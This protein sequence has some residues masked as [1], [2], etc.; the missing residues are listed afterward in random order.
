MIGFFD[1]DEAFKEFKQ[2]FESKGLKTRGIINYEK[3]TLF[4][5]IHNPSY[6]YS[7]DGRKVSDEQIKEGLLELVAGDGFTYAYR[8]LRA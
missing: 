3:V 2:H 4:Q 8:K 7:L 6:F 1:L 5:W